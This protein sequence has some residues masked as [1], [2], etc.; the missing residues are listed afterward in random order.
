MILFETFEHID[1]D[2]Q[3]VLIL[4]CGH[5]FT[6]ES[7]DQIARM[8]FAYKVDNQLGATSLK[9]MDSTFQRLQNCPSCRGSLVGVK[10]YGRINNRAITDG[11]HRKYY[12]DLALGFVSLSKNFEKVVQDMETN[13]IRFHVQLRA[14]R[15]VEKARSL[16][17]RHLLPLV[18]FQKSLEKYIHS[19][20][21]ESQPQQ[22]LYQACISFILQDSEDGFTE[23]I[24]VRPPDLKFAV[25]G[26]CLRLQAY[27]TTALELLK[28]KNLN[29]LI[30]EPWIAEITGE[31]LCNGLE[32]SAEY[33]DHVLQEAQKG[34]LPRPE[35]L[36]RLTKARLLVLLFRN[37][38]ASFETR[39]AARIE[40]KRE[41]VHIA[42]RIEEYPGILQ[43]FTDQIEQVER[44][45]SDE[46]Y[47]Q[48]SMS[49]RL[50]ILQAM[51]GDPHG[52][53]SWYFCENQH[54]FSIGECGRPMEMATCPE[55]G[56][57]VGGLSHHMV[58]GVTEAAELNTFIAGQ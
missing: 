53:V 33:A 39:S 20:I 18:R 22:K 48:V 16:L 42:S 35:V 30:L 11:I 29:H 14:L 25:Q 3:P 46:F 34:K 43:I 58:A 19:A 27:L 26:K 49:E 23:Y 54:P 6:A 5:I 31:F 56:A 47:E 40:G 21:E 4:K 32:A 37:K 2:M 36:I 41:L 9:Y 10:R 28:M 1:L 38:S 52:G 55:C 24:E 15:T 50:E 17:E 57:Q 7:L 8:D 51:R 44:S 13:S 12:E 45:L